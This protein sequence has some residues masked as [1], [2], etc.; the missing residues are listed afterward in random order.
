MPP[1][2]VESTYA[3]ASFDQFRSGRGVWTLTGT[4]TENN[5]PVEVRTTLH[6][7]RN[8]LEITRETAEAG[9]PFTFRH[10]YRFVRAARTN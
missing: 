4:G 8:I 9:K 7:G 1:G 10:S 3:I 6:I 5:A 2:K